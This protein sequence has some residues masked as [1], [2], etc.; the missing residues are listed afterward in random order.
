MFS[1]FLVFNASI[2][3][4]SINLSREI[5]IHNVFLKKLK[6]K[7]KIKQIN[8]LPKAQKLKLNQAIKRKG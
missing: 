6:Y 3:K 5:D 4:S 2:S 7:I 8:K 1:I